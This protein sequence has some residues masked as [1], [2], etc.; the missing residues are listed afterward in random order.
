MWRKLRLARTF[1]IID[2]HF[3][4]HRWQGGRDHQEDDFG[5]DNSRSGDFLMI[6]ADGM[7]GHAGGED[8]SSLAVR[9]FMDAYSATA[10][11]GTV[12]QRLRQ[13]LQHANHQLALKIK[14]NPQLQG[15]GC[16]LVGAVITNEEQLEWI[17]VGDS[18]LW[19]YN[20]GRLRRLNA[21]HSMKPLLQDQVQ[22]GELTPA[23]AASHPDRNMLRAALTGAEIELLDQ[24][25]VPL[26]LYPGDCILLASDGIFTLSESEI[27]KFLHQDLPAQ[28]LVDRL[29]EVVAS[30]QRK[31]QD[32]ATA[33]IVKIPDE[34]E[35][36]KLTPRW[37]WQTV[38]LGGLLI[39]TGLFAWVWNSSDKSSP[40]ATVT[41]SPGNSP[42]KPSPPTVNPSGESPKTP[43]VT[44]PAI[45]SQPA[46]KPEKPV[47]EKSSKVPAKD[48]NKDKSKPP[49]PK[50]AKDGLSE[51]SSKK[52]TVK[53]P[54]EAPSKLQ[55][56]SNSSPQE[57]E[58][59]TKK[60]EEK[61]RPLNKQKS[62]NSVMEEQLF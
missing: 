59:K 44:P 48:T 54:Q 6:L 49:K 5:F 52:E 36:V 21:D 51:K 7:G 40:P 10:G 62:G 56:S 2:K 23:A 11:S 61:L 18:P 58:S 14:S 19:L 8:A 29:L 4:G 60:E 39:L 26:E 30:K 50:S 24:S 33:L 57:K 28:E 46:E 53:S 15:M 34:L 45:E 55:D 1:L 16:T 13:A 20:A 3:G 43:P 38:V 25:S 22:R 12:A 41:S 9:A 35:P 47:D 37:R 31:D 27:S 17:S 42:V 32:N